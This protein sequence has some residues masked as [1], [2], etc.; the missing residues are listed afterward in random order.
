M[1]SLRMVPTGSTD[2][3]DR[4]FLDHAQRCV[5][6]KAGDDAAAQRVEAGP[7]SVVVIAQIKDVGGAGFDRHLLRWGDV[8]DPR[9]G[10][11]RIDRS[12]GVGVVDDVQLDAADLGREPRPIEATRI[13]PQA[14]GI[15]QVGG[16]AERPAQRAVRP[17]RHGGEQ[18]REQRARAQRI[19]V[20]QG[21]AARRRHAKVVKP[22]LVALKP[23]FDL[24]QAGGSFEL[25][26]EQRH[27]LAFG[28]QSPHPPIR[29]MP[30]NQTIKHIPGHALQQP[31]K[32]AIVMPHGIVPRSCP[33]RSQQPRHKWNQSHAPCPPILNRTA[34]GQARP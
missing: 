20:G 8:I 31:M 26:V 10:D 27:E 22:A 4:Q 17:C 13:E 18:L 25:T 14:A 24:A 32:N 23:G 21:R 3:I 28:A 16:V 19:G 7:P 33:D 29:S 15:D 34:V 12:L 1:R 6:L 2:R 9:R 5:A 30:L 11:R